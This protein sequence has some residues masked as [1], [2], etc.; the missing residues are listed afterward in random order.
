MAVIQQANQLLV[1]NPQ[2]TLVIEQTLRPI[3]NN[4]SCHVTGKAG[5]VDLCYRLLQ[6]GGGYHKSANFALCSF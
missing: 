5:G 3:K 4:N 1:V 6:G 2:M